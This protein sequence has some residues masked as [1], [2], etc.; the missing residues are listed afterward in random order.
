M[1]TRVTLAFADGDHDFW[2]PMSRVVAFER[3]ADTSIFALFHA[4]GESLGA[5][6]DGVKV[7]IGG[8][9]ARIRHCQSLIR[10]ALIGGGVSEQI[11]REMIDVYC[12]PNRPAIH[13]MALAWEILN[14]AIYGIKVE[15]SK[16]KSED[17]PSPS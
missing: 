10:N 4:I 8:S 12:Y 1:E 6:A 13:D 9:N 16:K 11:A 17:D 2:L 7:L 3:E 5:A 15:G 14:A